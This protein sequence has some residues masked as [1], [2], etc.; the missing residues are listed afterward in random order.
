M[1][2]YEGS[3]EY[4]GSKR[5]AMGSAIQ[6]VCM[7]LGFILDLLDDCQGWRLKRPPEEGLG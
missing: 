2:I 6:K 1:E 5:A 7:I 4:W 3:E